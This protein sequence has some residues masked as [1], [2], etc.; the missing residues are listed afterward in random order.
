M[1]GV[2]LDAVR[3][4]LQRPLRAVGEHLHKRCGVVGCH[5]VKVIRRKFIEPGGLGSSGK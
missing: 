4:G 1:A 5:F 3:A 2:D